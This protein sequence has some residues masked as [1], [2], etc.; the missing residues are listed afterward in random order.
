MHMK[1]MILYAD[2][3]SHPLISM[4]MMLQIMLCTP[5]LKRDDD[6]TCDVDEYSTYDEWEVCVGMG[7]SKM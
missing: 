5:V 6:S 7:S 4:H 2:G 3:D 1:M